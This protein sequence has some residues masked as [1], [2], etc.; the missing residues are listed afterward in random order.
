WLFDA[1]VNALIHLY[2]IGVFTAFTLSQTGM[3]RYWLRRKDAGWRKKAIVNGAG[4]IATTV[5]AVLVIQTK[6]LA[7]AWAVTVAI[8]LLVGGF[9]GINRHYRKVARR[10]RAGV[11]AVAAAPPATNQVVLYVESFDAALHEAV[12][13]A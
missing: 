7:G 10:L 5:V 4:A 13:Y 12:W 3:V 8:P 11:A 2:V 9:Y 1:D 6:F